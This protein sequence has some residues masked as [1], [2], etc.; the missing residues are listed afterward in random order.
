[1][2]SNI[3]AFA[4]SMRDFAETLPEAQL[5]PFRDA[6][7]LKLLSSVVLNTPVDRGRLRGNWQTTAGGTTDAA[8]ATEDRSGRETIAKGNAT[9]LAARVEEVI[10][11]QNNLP[12]AVVVEEGL[13]EPA[14]PGPSN[15]PRPTRT[16]K[17]F[18]SGG[19]S[20][21]APQ[22]ML[23]RALEEVGSEFP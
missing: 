11:L 9:I 12:Y 19:Y 17:V 4:E 10:W 22:G 1:M 13:F 23:A 15:D 21:A 7:G 16:G 14:D 2:S 3:T 8:L 18:V 5:K 20:L 6:I